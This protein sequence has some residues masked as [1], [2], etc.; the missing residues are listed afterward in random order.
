MCIFV[1]FN[2]NYRKARILRKT[3]F[4]FRLKKIQFWIYLRYLKVDVTLR[5]LQ[6]SES[7][8]FVQ[9]I[10]EPVNRISFLQASVCT[11]LCQP[12]M[13]FC[14]ILN[15][16]WARNTCIV[17]HS[18]F[19]KLCAQY[20]WDSITLLS[21]A[22]KEKAIFLLYHLSAEGS[23]DQNIISR[24]IWHPF[25]YFTWATFSPNL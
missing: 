4:W 14:F 10:T 2:F 18:E 24:L 20:S 7:V 3:K 23:P 6:G 22:S 16:I 25:Q 12:T 11:L 17:L 5:H 1:M 13:C 19:L 21:Q 9:N 15:H 8:G